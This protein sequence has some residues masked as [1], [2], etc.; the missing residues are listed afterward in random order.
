MSRVP[1]TDLER[2]EVATT[3]ALYANLVDDLRDVL[4]HGWPSPESLPDAPVL[5]DWILSQRSSPNLEGIAVGHPLLEGWTH[6][7]ILHALSVRAGVARTQSR[8]YRLGSPM[9]RMIDDGVLPT[10][11]P[12]R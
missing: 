7:S 8:W 12:R 2:S 11:E 6:T 1:L 3:L 10:C 9:V 5:Q 4:E